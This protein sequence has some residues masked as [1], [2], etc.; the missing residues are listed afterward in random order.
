MTASDTPSGDILTETSNGS[1]VENTTEDES[2]KQT[3]GDRKRKMDETEISGGNHVDDCVS[4]SKMQKS[5]FVCLPF[6]EFN[7]QNNFSE[8]MQV[9]KSMWFSKISGSAHQD[10]LESFYSPQA[11]LYDGY[12]SRMLHARP[13]MMKN[14]SIVWVDLGGGTGSSVE[15]MSNALDEGWFSSVVVL[16]LC[17]SLHKIAEERAKKWPGIVKA[18]LGDACNQ[19]EEG[20]PPAGSCDLVTFSY[21]LVM[22]PDWKGAI[23][24][25]LRLLRPGGRLC[26]CDFT[27]LPQKGQWTVTQEMWKRIFARDHVHLSDE[28]LKYLKSVTE[29]EKEDCGFG[30]FPYVPLLKAG[31]YWYVGKKPED[32]DVNPTGQ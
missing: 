4:P 29:P 13:P 2:V 9:L 26:V 6:S 27:V 25:A 30:S 31:W 17:P 7:V 16:D 21:S 28:H 23:A 32:A 11:K 19:N 5:Q 18:V 3:D 14:L 15:Y 20:L 12:R 22:I 1:S 24:N 8:D 10:I